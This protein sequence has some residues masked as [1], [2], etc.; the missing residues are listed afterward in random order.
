MGAEEEAEKKEEKSDSPP[1]KSGDYSLKEESSEPEKD[2]KQDIAPAS[3]A[4]SQT[5]I[6][7]ESSENEGIK[8]PLAVPEEVEK[9]E[10]KADAVPKMAGEDSQTEKPSEP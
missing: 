6:S 5:Q 10:E 9:K 3:P 4:K 8:E 2:A 1:E 7:K